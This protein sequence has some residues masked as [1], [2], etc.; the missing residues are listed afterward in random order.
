MHENGTIGLY[1]GCQGLYMYMGVQWKQHGL[2][3]KAMLSKP[4]TIVNFK[5]FGNFTK[6]HVI[7]I[8]LI[9]FPYFN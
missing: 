9:L 2:C 6:T 8:N 7:I 5:N 1:K 3:V 4:L